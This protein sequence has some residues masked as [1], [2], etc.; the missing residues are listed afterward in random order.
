MRPGVS[1]SAERNS[2]GRRFFYLGGVKARLDDGG[3]GGRVFARSAPLVVVAVVF[4]LPRYRLRLL[5][6]PLWACLFSAPFWRGVVLPITMRP[7]GGEKRF[8]HKQLFNP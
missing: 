5:G 3:D 8:R 7:P 4:V 1:S 2:Q 6:T